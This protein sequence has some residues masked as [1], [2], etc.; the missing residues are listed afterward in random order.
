MR[1]R[2]LK[3]RTSNTNL[4]IVF[5]DRIGKKGLLRVEKKQI[6]VKLL[7]YSIV[8]CLHRNDH[9]HHH[10]LDIYK[11][12]MM[13]TIICHQN[14]IDRIR[15]QNKI[16]CCFVSLSVF[17]RFFICLLCTFIYLGFFFHHLLDSISM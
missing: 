16:K 10:H 17:F 9:H 4:I 2:G 7:N 15:W 14:Q 3:S 1:E 11:T 12:M 13:M 8:V 5:F 6:N